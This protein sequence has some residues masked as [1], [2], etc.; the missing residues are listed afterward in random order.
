MSARV[1]I[2]H[3]WFPQYRRAF[4]EELSQ[5][6]R[7]RGIQL[8]IFHGTP[9]PEWKDRGD[10]V[11]ANY[12]TELP[13]KF[14]RIGSK[15]IAVRNVTQVRRMGPYD[16]LIFEQA[17]RNIETYSLLARPVSRMHAY[18][19]H[20]RTYTQRSSVA[21]E[22]I[23]R[24]MTN[25][26]D[27]FFGY[28]EAGVRGVIEAGYPRSRSTVVVNSIDTESLLRDLSGVQS[29]D[30]N[31][32]KCEHD[33][34]SRT[35]LFIGGLD[36]SKRIEFLI[37]AAEQVAE[38]VPGFRL[39][40]AGDGSDRPTVEKAAR[41]LSFV[42]YIGNIEGAAKAVALV[43]SSILLMPGRV[44]LVAVDSFA[45]SRPIVTT[46]WP[47]H[48]PEFEYLQPEYDSLVTTD[49]LSEYSTKIASLL[50]DEPALAR[51]QRGAGSRVGDFSAS[52]MAA[53]FGQGVLSALETGPI[54]RFGRS[55]GRRRKVIN[56]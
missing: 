4:F 21:Q 39:L 29:S 19:G 55:T 35:G 31:K 47:Y 40:I 15:H 42:K 1:A 34:G 28:T 52:T 7:E 22:R 20:G 8:D 17:V 30:L 2:I 49:S 27:W 50:F 26:A 33:L 25:S 43:A 41:N 46:D 10:A 56:E 44:G 11:R 54:P 53:N 24:H 51:L 36:P 18:W 5:F 45:A 12:A 38:K 32:F 48:A 23:K 14:V 13:T 3:P 16:L 37:A 9:P 6:L